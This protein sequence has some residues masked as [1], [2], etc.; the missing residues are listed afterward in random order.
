[1]T[2][3]GVMLNRIVTGNNVKFDS[4]S[5]FHVQGIAPKSRAKVCAH[6]RIHK[7]WVVVTDRSNAAI[8]VSC[9][10]LGNWIRCF[11]F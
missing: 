11:M 7:P 8:L 1:M 4:L 5:H 3:I 2:L 6:R 10:L 9:L